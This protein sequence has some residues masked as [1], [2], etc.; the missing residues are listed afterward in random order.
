M[1]KQ[2]PAAEFICCAVGAGVPSDIS[3]VVKRV[4]V[5]KQS[6]FYEKGPKM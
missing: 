6:E 1:L 3:N 5:G 2:T 4:C